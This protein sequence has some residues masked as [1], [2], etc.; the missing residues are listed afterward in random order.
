MYSKILEG[1]LVKKIGEDWF[2]KFDTT[3]LIGAIDFCVSTKLKGG[4]INSLLWA[5]AKQGDEDK[6]EMLAQLIITIGK[7]RTMDKNYPPKFLGAFDFKKIVF[8]PYNDVRDIFYITDFNWNVTPSN[9]KTKEFILI[10]EKLQDILNKHLYEYEFVKDEFELKYFINNNF[11]L[12]ENNS[13]ILI[14]QNNF[15]PIYLRWLETVKPLIEFDWN[16]G[17]KLNIIDSDFY[18]ADLFI[19]D[20]DTNDISD[21]TSIKD[22]LFVSFNNGQ[23]EITKENLKNLYGAVIKIND[24]S[25]YEQFWKKYKRSPVVDFQDYI[26]DRRDLLIPQDIRQIRGAYFTPQF[27]V[28]LSQKYITQELG[29]NWQEEYYIWDCAAG[30][31]NL[32]VGLK[33]K[34]NI[35]AS[36]KGMADIN[37][38]NDRIKNGANLIKEHIFEFD[39]LNDD[40]DKIPLELQ[41]IIND[42]IKRKKLVIYINPPYA[43][44][45]DKKSLKGEVAK[46]GVEQ[47]LINKKYGHILGQANAELYAQFFIRIYNEIPGC[48]LAEFSTLKII[49]GQHF[50][51]FRNHFLAKLKSLF[52]VPANTFDNVTGQFPIGFFIWD[53]NEKTRFMKIIADVYNENG[54]LIQ[55]KSIETY[56][57]EKYINDWIKPYR[58]SK[59]DKDIIGKFPFKGNDFQNQNMIS[60]VHQNMIYNKEAGQ[61]L[62]NPSNLIIS[63]VYFAVRKCISANWLNDRDQFLSPNENW[64][65]DTE[66]Q[67]DCFMYTLFKNNIQSKFGKNKWIPFSEIEVDAN[68]NFEDKF[69]K[70]FIDGKIKIQTPIDLFSTDSE[71]TMPLAFSLQAFNVLNIAKEL[72]KYYFKQNNVNTNASLYDIREYFQGRDDK[73][74]MKNKSDDIEYTKIIGKLRGALKC[75]EEKIEPKI[76]KYGFLK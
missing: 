2:K 55:E 18:L 42:P 56:Q 65:K 49:Q 44:A 35:W 52:L 24:K 53:T 71:R 76:Y 34:Y 48:V 15:V 28:E 67:N 23:Y 58:A 13:K 69:M 70:N 3:N 6:F 5:E 74:K 7:A 19:D 54:E 4:E 60:I 40:F 16:I 41:N 25:K 12:T 46:A 50:K 63:C 68:N 10:K 30:T 9:H 73:G 75:L 27:W 59:D 39:F 64:I 61:F 72:W 20:K 37:V 32:L 26:I 36:T 43:E 11:N 66:F 21:D 38:M 14:D 45:S 22:G 8:V 29:E 62:I 47:S 57:N 51:D 17:K 31:G 33:N 1:S